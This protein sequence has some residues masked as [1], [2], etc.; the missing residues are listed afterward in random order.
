VVD[1]SQQSDGFLRVARGPRD[2]SRSGF[3]L[4]WT[5]FLDFPLSNRAAAILSPARQGPGLRPQRAMTR[6]PPADEAGGSS[7]RAN[8]R[9]GSGASPRAHRGLLPV[10]GSP[11]QVAHHG[12]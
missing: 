9:T 5:V 3:R 11:G 2:S 8:E 4:S 12:F 7:S 1:P 6:R 10:G